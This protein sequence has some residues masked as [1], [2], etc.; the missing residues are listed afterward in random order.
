MLAGTLDL[1]LDIAAL[2]LKLGNVLFNEELDEFFQLFLIHSFTVGPFTY[3][4]CAPE[5]RAN[6]SGMDPATADI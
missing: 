5:E 2:Q 4:G 6:K 1:D 3:P